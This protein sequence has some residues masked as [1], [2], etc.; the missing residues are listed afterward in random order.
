MVIKMR[1]STHLYCKYCKTNMRDYGEERCDKCYISLT[2]DRVTFY[3][4]ESMPIKQRLYCF[5]ES[6]QYKFNLC[7]CVR[8][9]DV[10]A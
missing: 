4:L 5:L 1:R 10:E 3:P 6:L 9:E 8:K 2:S 7:S